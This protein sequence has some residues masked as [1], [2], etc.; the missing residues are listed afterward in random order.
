M[1]SLNV[2][3]GI[4]VEDSVPCPDGEDVFE[5]APSI[6]SS[7]S[8]TPSLDGMEEDVNPLSFSMQLE[9]ASKKGWNRNLS[10]F[11]II[12]SIREA[13]IKSGARVDMSTA[14]PDYG[15]PTINS[16]WRRYT[17]RTPASFNRPEVEAG[18]KIILPVSAIEELTRELDTQSDS[19][20]F[21]RY[22]RFLFSFLFF[23]FNT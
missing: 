12:R 7:T 22:T 9:D 3:H 16:F 10:V 8:T 18:G 11:D 13:L 15:L 1:S 6:G 5:A 19:L 17:A 21:E 4:S 14:S 23:I 2:G 20:G